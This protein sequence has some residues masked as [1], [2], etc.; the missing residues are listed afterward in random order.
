MTTLIRHLGLRR[1]AVAVAVLAA[2]GA[3]RA[4]SSDAETSVAVGVGSVTGETAD[5][6]LFGQYNG[7]RDH[8][9]RGLLGVD[10]T[11]RNAATG[12]LTEFV[13]TDLLLDTRELSF[14]WK[15]QGNWK[16]SASYS[17]LIRRDPYTVNTGLVGA[18]TTAPQVS[19]LMGG[20]GTG[21]IFDLETKRK[22][23]GLGFSK[24]FG[25]NV[26]LEVELKSENK[27][28]SRL[29]GIGM[30]CPSAVAPGCLGSAGAAADWAVLMLPEPIDANHSQVEARLSYAGAKLRLS[31][32]Y[33]GSFYRNANSTLNPNVGNT[34]NSPLGAPLPVNAQL[35]PILNLPVA[36]PPD[37]EAHHFDVTGSYAFTPTTRANFKLA[38]SEAKQNQDFVGSGFA[39]PTLPAGV[40]NLAGKLETTL[41]Q[42]GISARPVPKLSLAAEA[43]YEDRNDKTPLALYNVEGTTA[44]TNRNY[45][46]TKLRG[47]LQATYQFPYALA[48]TVG[49]DYENIDR[50]AFT[51][52]SALAGVS[53]LR[54]E[55]EEI[56][57]RVELRRRM[58]ETVSGALSFI[59][60]DRDGSNWLRDNSGLGVTEVTDPASAFASTAIFMPT[61]ADRK[62]DKVRLLANWQ[63]T[64]SV[65]L[66]LTAENGKDRFTAPTV[67]AL[68]DTK[69]SLYSLDGSYAASDAWSFNAYLSQGRQKLNQARPAGYVLAF[70]NKTTAFGLGVAGKPGEKLEVGGGLSFIN[71]KNV[72]DQSLDPG[73][74]LNTAL[75]LAATGGLPEIVFRRTELRLFGRYA[76]SRASALRLDGI[77]QRTKFDDWS[78]GYNGVPFT[79]SD[80]TTL[81]LQP[82][83]NVTFVGVTYIYSWR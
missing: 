38:Y 58:T 80:N 43:R 6:G 21:G 28:G 64:D 47:K 33:Y 49:V 75:L 56:A 71:D 30:N 11:R 2:F 50:G 44:H 76:L 29:F 10:Y 14:L 9:V 46:S 78:Y 62:R 70:D 8:D 19:Y 51:P 34:L 7:W 63:A 27:D 15:R 25:P 36:L 66:Q 32:G 39:A 13:G 23:L 67:Y 26:A 72:Y 68:R 42:A 45:S 83:Q 3:A 73:A 16:F 57:Y 52:T 53:A 54:Y 18:G 12:T 40:T 17:E 35:Q 55:T 41:A 22:G 31:G 5:R 60:S 81:T 69:M 74:S 65:S 1:T 59:R 4:Q 79:Y 37:N 61:L 20:T 48:G 82:Q 24:W 77:H